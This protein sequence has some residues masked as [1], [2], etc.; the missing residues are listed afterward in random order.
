MGDD[1][2]N[3]VVTHGLCLSS[4]QVFFL[5]IIYLFQFMY[6]FVYV[7]DIAGHFL[8]LVQC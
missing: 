7:I 8:W 5:K 3:V 2:G 1:I 6:G 4:M